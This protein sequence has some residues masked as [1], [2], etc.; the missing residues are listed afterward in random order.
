MSPVSRDPIH[1]YIYMFSDQVND[2]HVQN[3]ALHF[4]RQMATEA[5]YI[6]LSV[7]VCVWVCMCAYVCVS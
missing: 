2:I 6:F 5:L 1:I 3:A 4:Q 7:C